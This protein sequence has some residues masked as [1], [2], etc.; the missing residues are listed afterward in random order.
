MIGINT[1]DVT[2]TDTART[3]LN[4]MLTVLIDPARLGTQQAFE[5]EAA[6]FVDWLR[7]ELAGGFAV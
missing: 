7:V 3:V 6:A 1:L 5:Q 4:G 2:A